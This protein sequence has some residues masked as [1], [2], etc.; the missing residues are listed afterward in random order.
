MQSGNALVDRLREDNYMK[1]NID[2]NCIVGWATKYYSENPM[3][4][5]EDFIGDNTGRHKKSGEIR[6]PA[7]F[8]RYIKPYTGE[9]NVRSNT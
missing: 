4:R 7:H 8:K 3:A 9:S 5:K 1:I 2:E 6:R